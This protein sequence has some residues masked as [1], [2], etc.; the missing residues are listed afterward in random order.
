MSGKALLLVATIG[1]LA[2]EHLLA[3]QHWFAGWLHK[4]LH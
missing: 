1:I 4:F 3:I 2:A